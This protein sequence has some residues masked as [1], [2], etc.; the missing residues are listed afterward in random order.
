MLRNVLIKKYVDTKDTQRIIG[1]SSVVYIK[2]AIITIVLLF[3]LYVIFALLDQSNPAE[4]W[5]WIFWIL[6]LILFAK[7][8]IDFLNLYLDCLILSKDYITFFLWD[9]LL[10]YKT[11]IF[12]WNKINTISWN[13]NGFWDKVTG[14][15]DILI[16]LEFDTEFPF[17][18]VNSPKKQVRKLMM[19]KE[20]FLSRQKQQVEKDLS[21]DNER[22]TVLV[23]AMSEVVK[24]YLDNKDYS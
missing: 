21:E 11:E 16:K 20:D 4:Y 5:K 2:K 23:E 6:W 15:W 17:A 24:E 8:V 22:F 13:Q 3:L 12:S 18:D 19:M 10:E 14:K 7:R 1:H 9:W